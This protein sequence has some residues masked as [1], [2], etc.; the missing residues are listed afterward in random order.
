MSD[1]VAELIAKNR[2]ASI[3][4]A[5]AKV[6][7]TPEGRLAVWSVLERCGIFQ[8][9][10]TGTAMDSWRAGFR[11][12]GLTLL[13]ERV[14]PHDVRT[15]ADMQLEHA[16]LMQRIQLQAELEAREDHDNA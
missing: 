9:T 7:G 15:F 10:T 1:A 8:V 2:S 4:A 5:W 13:T 16:Q 6:L 12:A 14:F 11:D 3:D